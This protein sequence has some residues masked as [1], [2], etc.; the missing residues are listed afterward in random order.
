M[1][2][3]GADASQVLACAP[4][5][6]DRVN[7]AKGR[8]S[9]ENVCGTNAPDRLRHYV[10]DLERMT[11]FACDENAEQRNQSARTRHGVC[12]QEMRLKSVQLTREFRC[13]RIK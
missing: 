10:P 9:A 11:G 7:H 2:P 5:C 12:Q 4:R 1:P 6:I 3:E 8:V 13:G